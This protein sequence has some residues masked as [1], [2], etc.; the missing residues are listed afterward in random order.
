LDTFQGAYC[1]GLHYL[2]TTDS[3]SDFNSAMNNL[4][5]VQIYEY[6]GGNN[7]DLEDNVDGSIAE[8][9]LTYSRSC[10]ITEYPGVCSDPYGR[11]KTWDKKIAS[12]SAKAYSSST[13]N[14]HPLTTNLPSSLNSVTAKALSWLSTIMLLA[15]LGLLANVFYFNKSDD[16]KEFDTE[17]EDHDT[18]LPLV[19]QISRQVSHASQRIADKIQDFA[20]AEEPAGETPI[21]DYTAPAKTSAEVP[22]THS[23]VRSAG[24]SVHSKNETVAN[25]MLAEWGIEASPMKNKRPRIAKLSK[26]MFAGRK[27]R[28]MKAQQ[29]SAVI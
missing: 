21:G 28:Q 3:L 2:K 12:A 17:K 23:S 29:K 10:S 26:W 27:T 25:A 5:C 18:S 15:G 20:E 11:K 16:T 1:D 7:R 22:S 8:T 13:V 19:K 9:I 6:G 24:A 4:Q 14:L